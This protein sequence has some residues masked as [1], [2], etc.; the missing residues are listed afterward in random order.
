MR[1]CIEDYPVVGEEL[2]TVRPSL[3]R[4]LQGM[5]PVAELLGSRRVEGGLGIL[6]PDH[7]DISR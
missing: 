1:L 7:G 4:S 2:D 3:E 5:W 6:G